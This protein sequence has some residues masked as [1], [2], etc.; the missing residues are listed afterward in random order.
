L[1]YFRPAT[2]LGSFEFVL[3]V[4]GMMSEQNDAPETTSWRTRAATVEGWSAL[5]LA[6]GSWSCMLFPRVDT[7]VYSVKELIWDFFPMLPAAIGFGLAVAGIRH[8][9][10][11]AR[12]VSWLACGLLLPLLI[13]LGY[14]AVQR[15]SPF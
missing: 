5:V 10:A 15:Q 6:I 1:G 9:V 7:L 12:A 2:Q 8:G 14:A 11:T 4:E 13:I 3:K